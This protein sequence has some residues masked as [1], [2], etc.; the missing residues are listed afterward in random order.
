MMDGMYKR[1]AGRTIRNEGELV[2]RTP[3]T[4][5]EA[6][7]QSLLFTNEIVYVN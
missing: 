4:P 6:L 5:W 1:K 3:L 7:A 2:E